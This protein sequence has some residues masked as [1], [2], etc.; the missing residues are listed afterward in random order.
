MRV[1][2][3]SRPLPLT[4]FRDGGI[5]G[6]CL[7]DVSFR[8]NVLTTVSGLP[9][10][11]SVAVL[12]ETYIHFGL[13]S[14]THFVGVEI[15]NCDMP[16]LGWLI[17]LGFLEVPTE[18]NIFLNIVLPTDVF[19]IFLYFASRSVEPGPVWV[20]RERELIHVRRNVA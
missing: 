19:Q 15:S 13:L 3:L 18:A 20:A 2:L 17:P 5:Q 4:K 1:K 12:H 8:S 9:G 11:N 16:L 10:L 7:E 6:I 14:P